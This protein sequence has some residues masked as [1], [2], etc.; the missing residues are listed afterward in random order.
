M[1]RKLST[2]LDNLDTNKTPQSNEMI[3]YILT[4][5]DCSE[6]QDLD[7]RIKSI[8]Q[9]RTLFRQKLKQDNSIS[10]RLKSISDKEVDYKIKKWMHD[11]YT[12]M[13]N[14]QSILDYIDSV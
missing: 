11:L 2:I 13:T 9:I 3:T 6:C 14:Y 8:L 12:Q 5:C 1:C 10:R 7:V 4:T